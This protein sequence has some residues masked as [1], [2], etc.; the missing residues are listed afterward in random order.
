MHMKKL[1]KLLSVIILVL[2]SNVAY[3]AYSR[4]SV[5]LFRMNYEE[6]E[7]GISIKPDKG[8]RTP[9]RPIA[10]TI[11]E[12]EGITTE[13]VIEDI[14]TYELWDIEGEEC[15]AVYANDIDVANHIFANPGEYQLRI[16]TSEYKYL[17]EITTQ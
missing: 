8:R 11:S 10:C 5:I 2:S 13:V 12:G 3:G 15:I 16:V 7:Q 6:P 9:A 1:L 4:L 17:G 14:E